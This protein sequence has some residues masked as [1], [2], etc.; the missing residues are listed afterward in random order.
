MRAAAL[1]D[2]SYRHRLGCPTAAGATPLPQLLSLP[3]P[4]LLLM[5]L[6]RTATRPVALNPEPA[7]FARCCVTAGVRGLTHATAV[8]QSPRTSWCR[9]C[10]QAR[11]GEAQSSSSL[12]MRCGTALRA[13]TPP[14][15]QASIHT[16]QHITLLRVV[17]GYLRAGSGSLSAQRSSRGPPTGA[18]RIWFK[19]RVNI[20]GSVAQ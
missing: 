1:H 18:A 14:A 2:H 19:L 13:E 8:V 20:F 16:Q 7:H 10:A 5:P 11:H 6:P 3:L 15:V 9:G 4:R 17:Q 12:G